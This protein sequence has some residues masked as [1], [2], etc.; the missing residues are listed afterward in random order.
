V[1][2]FLSQAFDAEPGEDQVSYRAVTLV[3]SKCQAFDAEPGEDQVSY[4]AVTLSFRSD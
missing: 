2:S 3:F 4:R 1:T